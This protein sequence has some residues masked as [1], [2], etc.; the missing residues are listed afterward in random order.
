MHWYLAIIYFPEHTLL[1][2]P[3]QE[4]IV[5]PRRSTRRIGVIIDSPEALQPD[6]ASRQPIPPDPDPPPNGQVHTVSSSELIGIDSPRTD[7]QKDENDVE[8]MVESGLAQADPTVKEVRAASPDT[9]VTQCPESPTLVYPHSSP[10]LHPA[11]LSTFNPQGDEAEQSNQL[12]S[13]RGS[14]EAIIRTSGI[15]TSTFYGTKNPGRGD[16]TPQLPPTNNSTPPAT[17]IEI[18]EDATIG[19]P[20]SELEEATECA[21]FFS[22]PRSIAHEF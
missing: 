2:R 14:E 1:L 10:A 18:E 11:T 15:S 6:P 17:E 7:D 12:A 3:V 4:T 8:R 13:L 21:S 19:N 20:E 9:L 5:H 16:V 22:S